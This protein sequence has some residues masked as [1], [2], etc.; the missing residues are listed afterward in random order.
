[1]EADKLEALMKE[2]VELK[3]RVEVLEGKKKRKSFT[4]PSLYELQAYFLERGSL[5][6]NDDAERFYDFY[7]SKNWFV[8]KTKMKD[9]KASV[10]NWI[11]GNKNNAKSFSNTATL[12][13]LGD[14]DF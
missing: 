9:W 5:T 14:T 11:R 1:M 3:E 2:I 10:R 4:K 8:G 7:E 6:C 13:N 12:T